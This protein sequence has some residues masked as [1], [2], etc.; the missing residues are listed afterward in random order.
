MADDEVEEYNEAMDQV[1]CP[2][3][4]QISIACRKLADLDIGKGKSDPYAILY[5][6]AEKDT[7]WYRIRQTETL[8]D[9]LDPDFQA[10]F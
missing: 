5:A 1:D 8:Q 6:K 7:K 3:K 4:V 9:D 10:I 2:H